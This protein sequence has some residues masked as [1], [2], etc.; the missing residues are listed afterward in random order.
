MTG[1]PDR[2]P[3]HPGEL[4]REEL[5]PESVRSKTEIAREL[6]IS[7]KRLND[8]LAERKPVTPELSVKLTKLFGG[9][10]ETW[11]GLQYGHD[12]WHAFREIDVPAMSSRVS[13]E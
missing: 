12:M 10:P 8:I 7:L 6:G 2:C 1:N 9:T 11:S 3:T 13:A 4:L 5:I